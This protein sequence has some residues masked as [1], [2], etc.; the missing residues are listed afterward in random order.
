MFDDSRVEWCGSAGTGRT[1]SGCATGVSQRAN[2]PDDLPPDE[3]TAEVAEQLFAVPQDGGA[4]S[5]STR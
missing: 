4:R 5:A 3:L 2:L 1:W